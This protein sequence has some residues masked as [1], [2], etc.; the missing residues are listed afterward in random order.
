MIS[1]S[2]VSR[3]RHFVLCTV[4]LKQTHA[5][6]KRDRERE[7]EG[8]GGGVKE[9]NRIGTDAGIKSVFDKQHT[10][11]IEQHCFTGLNS[12]PNGTHRNR[13]EAI[14]ELDHYNRK[15]PIFRMLG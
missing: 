12:F 14:T 6:T 4:L 5:H 8:G 11:K 13:N 7:R 9:G 10:Y 15:L 2:K 3:I 1:R